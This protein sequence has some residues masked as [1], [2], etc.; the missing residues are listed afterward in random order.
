MSLA[1][2]I[3]PMVPTFRDTMDSSGRAHAEIGRLARMLS[4]I[5]LIEI[6][7]LVGSYH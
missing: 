3:I 2:A 7:S 4:A 1:V 6:A 5:L